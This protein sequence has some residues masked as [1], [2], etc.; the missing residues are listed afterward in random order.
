MIRRIVDGQVA[1]RYAAGWLWFVREVDLLAQRL[2][3]ASGTLTGDAIRIAE[4]IGVAPANV[5]VGPS[6]SVS[7]N[8]QLAFRGRSASRR[9]LAWFD[10]KGTRLSSVIDDL[11]T[12]SNPSL[13][14]TDRSL[15]VQRTLQQNI[16]IWSL[17]LERGAFTRL[18][19]DPAIDSMPVWS[20]DG[21][22]ILFGSART[23]QGGLF[24]MPVDAIGSERRINLPST[25]NPRVACDW[26]GRY[27]VYKEFDAKSSTDLFALAIDEDGPPIP[28]ARTPYDERDAEVSPDGK[29]IAY[30][31]NEA[32]RP[33]IYLQ[34]FPAPGEKIPV[35]PEGGRQV[36]WSRD[37]HELFYVSLNGDLMSAAV[38]AV[39][40]VH[41]PVRL[42]ATHLAPVSA[43]SRQQ[44]VVTNDGRFLMITTDD[45]PA[46]PINLVLNWA[47]LRTR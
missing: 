8:G 10:R 16:D 46:P 34:P 35:S 27:I 15:L 24:T 14:H 20:P 9:R 29:W 33:S 32:M 43:I 3:P 4:D 12:G 21:R 13:N 11:Q 47:G 45:P 26:N 41:A 42:F 36:R 18:T 19:L 23:G 28:I 17:D 5:P 22:R 38:D 31:S 30:E 1:G 39:G 7:D 6:F 40:H 44:Y 37:G 2:D 25:D